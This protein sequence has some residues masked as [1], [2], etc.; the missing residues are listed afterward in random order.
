MSDGIDSVRVRAGTL[1]L[2]DYKI[3][4]SD[5]FSVRPTVVDV[6]FIF[7][8][9]NAVPT[10]QGTQIALLEQLSVAMTL[11]LAKALAINLRKIMQVIEDEIGPIP[12]GEQSMFDD[13]VL[14]SVRQTIRANPLITKNISDF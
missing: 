10:P 8:V 2:P 12:I 7:G 5:T 13:V 11:P 14:D 4:Y 9:R 1:R 3:I 6:T